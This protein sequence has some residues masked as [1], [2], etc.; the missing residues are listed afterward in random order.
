MLPRCLE[1]DETIEIPTTKGISRGRSPTRFSDPKFAY[2][3]RPQPLWKKQ[4]MYEEPIDTPVGRISEK[5]WKLILKTGNAL[6]NSGMQTKI[7][8]TLPTVSSLEEPMS[9]F[10]E[11][12][13]TITFPPEKTVEDLDKEQTQAMT[14]SLTKRRSSSMKKHHNTS[15]VHTSALASRLQRSRMSYTAQPKSRGI[16]DSQ[17]QLRIMPRPRLGSTLRLNK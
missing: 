7:I 4:V 14:R 9:D 11:E 15:R 13:Q 16:F 3:P 6:E 12:P 2:K 8:P 10:Y 17:E 5:S 1:L